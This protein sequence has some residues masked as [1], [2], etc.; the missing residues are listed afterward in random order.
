MILKNAKLEKLGEYKRIETKVSGN[1]FRHL[2][3]IFDKNGY[4]QHV[5]TRWEKTLGF[6]REELLGKAAIEFVHPEDREATLAAAKKLSKGV[7]T[8]YF[9]NRYRCKDGSYKWLMWTGAELTADGSAYAIAYDISDRK[10]IEKALRESE[11]RYQTL[12]EV[13]PVGIFHTDAEGRYLY[14][15]DRM[16]EIAG[17]TPREALGQGWLKAIHPEDRDRV[18]QQWQQAVKAELPFSSEYRFQHS[19]GTTIWVFGQAAVQQNSTHQIKGYIGTTTDISDRKRTEEALRESEQRLQAI[20]DNSPAVIFAK[21]TQGRYIFSNQ[22]HEKLFGVSRKHI[23]GKT[24]YDILPRDIA[25][26]FRESDRKVLETGTPLEWE[27][28]V[29]QQDGIHTYIASMFPLYDATGVLYAVCGVATDITERKRAEQERLELADRIQLLLES[30]GEGIYAIDLEGSCTLINKAAAEM[31][32]YKPEELLGKDMHEL[33]HHTHSDG[34]AYPSSECPIFCAFYKRIG[35]RVDNEVFW[36]R[37]GTAFPVEYSSYPILDGE[38]IK[39][40]VIVFIDITE[41]KQA[42]A[43]LYKTQK[44]WEHLVN[45]SPAVI[46]SC[47]ANDDFGATFVSQNV[48]MQMGYAPKDF[49]E[50]SHFWLSH[51][52]PEDAPRVLEGMSHLFERDYDCNEYRFLHKDGTYR[53]MHDEVRAIR[54]NE[55][56]LLELIG[57]WQE[58]TDRKQAELALK[59]LNETLESRVQERTAELRNVIRQLEAEI[60]DRQR[61]QEA[62]ETA[63]KDVEIGNNLLNSVI[64]GTAN[65]IFVKD[66]EGRYV[67]IN[68]AGASVFGRTIEEIIGK[69]D[70]ELLPPKI[71]RKLIQTD[72][73]I[74]ASGKTERLEE[75]LVVNGITRTY[76]STKCPYPN[77]EGKIVGI[78]GVTQDITDRKL[79]EEKLRQTTAELK[80][81]FK[82]LP[83]IYFRLA[84]DGTILDYMAGQSQHLYAPPQVFLGKRMDE[85]LPAQIGQKLQDAIAEL[86]QTRSLVTIEYSL[87]M[88]QGECFYE[89]RL[90]PLLEDGT[91]VIV[92]DI[93]ARKRSE[94]ALRRSEELYS[95]LARN[96][97]NGSVA[98]FDRDLRYL[99]ADGTEL[100]AIGL[101]KELMEGKTLWEVWPPEIWSSIESIYRAALAGTK[102]VSEMPYGDRTYLLQILPVTNQEGEIFAGMVLVQNITDR[103][104]AEE[105]LRQSEERFRQLYTQAQHSTQ[106]AEEKAYQL[107]QTLHQLKQTQ[108]QL[109]QSEK[110]SSLGQMVAGVAHEIN[111]PVNFIYGNLTHADR[112][113][114]DL[115]NLLHFYHQHYPIPPAE[116][117]ALAEEIDLD[118][119]LEDL[120]KILNSMKIG[121]NRIREIVLSLRN[122][123]RLDEADMKTV[124][125]H[126]GIENTLLILHNRLKAKPNYPP[127]EVVKVYGNL[128]PVECYA[129]QLNQVFMNILNNAIDALENQPAPRKIEIRTEIVT[130]QKLATDDTK[131]RIL[132]RVAIRVRDNGPGM[133]EA[134]KARLF[135]PFFT[136]KPV[137]KGTGLGLSISYQIVVEKHGGVLNCL[138]ELGQGSEFSI[139]IPVA[140]NKG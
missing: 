124:D 90:S 23:E 107:E 139:E 44:R 74:I 99:L 2:V 105:A 60:V 33:I 45:A 34:S 42:Q 17:L 100:G 73:R 118:F 30:T 31:L 9:E 93:S 136:T 69:K 125:I 130:T 131:Q 22:R 70:L 82:A 79:S 133:T 11:E 97:P 26:R 20:L 32:G 94:E 123:S 122:F 109:V 54:D 127:I 88:P 12:T 121:A 76:F 108:A 6:R 104:V 29:P 16:Q 47:K 24:D 27:E 48:T 14:V 102:T 129:G 96:F 56:N 38:A 119:L 117:Q 36:R 61:V 67:M 64:E 62:L 112:Y 137:G 106:Q 35:C 135:D 116:I 18:L 95:T 101:S 85:V 43:E 46:Y 21:D 75:V 50:D 37:D 111:N 92:R 89:A 55:G 63:K 58:I 80:A 84:S 13:S 83:D 7:N 114:Q 52:H 72:R 115:L 8:I 57:F 86:Q 71:A 40:A 103:K 49:L 126:E 3:C 113:I 39:G 51:I 10:H 4:F 120:P 59:Q 91:I 53:W 132:D 78:I 110:M 1:F 25:D 66:I 65:P 87:P 81:V 128:P 98:L 134:V 15:N 138:S 77:P 140:Q 41:R 19:D 28:L 5:N 68:S